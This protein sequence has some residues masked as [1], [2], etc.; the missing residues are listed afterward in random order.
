MACNTIPESP[1]PSGL[2]SILLSYIT[3]STKSMEHAPEHTRSSLFTMDDMNLEDSLSSLLLPSTYKVLQLYEENEPDV[4][5]KKGC[6]SKPRFSL[7][8]LL[9]GIADGGSILGTKLSPA[10]REENAL[11]A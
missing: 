6:P 1:N 4:F 3:N 7:K 2:E 10:T 5:E 8:E 11:A 9:V